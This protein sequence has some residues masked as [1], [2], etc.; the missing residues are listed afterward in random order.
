MKIELNKSLEI[1]NLVS[2]AGKFTQNKYQKEVLDIISNYKKFSLNQGDCLITTTKSI[3]FTDGDQVLD[4]EILLPVSKII[5]VE[6]PYTFKNS[7]K[8]CNAI[9]AKIEDIT[10]LQENLN[11]INEYICKNELQPITPAYL[12]QKKSDL[13]TSID[14]YIGLNPNIL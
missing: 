6:K 1:K 9:Y 14:V 8:I 7:I 2:R 4:V 12:I 11:E 10:L 3:E 13:K 5:T